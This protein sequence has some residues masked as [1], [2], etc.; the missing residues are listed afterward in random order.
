MLATLSYQE[1]NKQKQISLPYYEIQNIAQEIY[2]KDKNRVEFDF[3][4]FENKYT[5]FNPYLDYILLQKQGRLDSFLMNENYSIYGTTDHTICYYSDVLIGLHKERHV[6][7]YFASD[8][9]SIMWNQP[10]YGYACILLADANRISHKNAK[11]H[12]LIINLYLHSILSQNKE[13]ANHYEE[14]ISKQYNNRESPFDE[15][16]MYAG[17]YLGVIRYVKLDVPQ[18]IIFYTSNQKIQTDLQTNW[19]NQ[20]TK[21]I[22]Y[23][24]CMEEKESEKAKQF[25]KSFS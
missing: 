10:N 7:P 2:E 3:Q 9:E 24:F 20:Q 1:V 8:N 25:I 19:L 21:A 13:I 18:P 5:Y 23:R 12:N 14:W 16:G 17:L 6:I 15:Y 11:T 22:C 4:T